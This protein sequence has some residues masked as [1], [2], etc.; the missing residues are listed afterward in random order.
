MV[1]STEKNLDMLKVS[2]IAYTNEP[3]NLSIASARTCYS[4]KGIVYPDDVS[5]DEKSIL[6]RDKIADRKSVV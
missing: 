5:K 6:L 4:S 3:Y 2:L 1:F